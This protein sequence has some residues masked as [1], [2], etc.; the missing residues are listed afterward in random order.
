[1][2]D[3]AVAC[4]AASAAAEGGGPPC[5]GAP[6]RAAP[7]PATPAAPTPCRA[8]PGAPQPL[9]RRPTEGLPGPAAAS[10]RT[11]DLRTCWTR[12]PLRLPPSV[13]SAPPSP[14]SM[15]Q[16]LYHVENHKSGCSNPNTCITTSRHATVICTEIRSR[17]SH[18]SAG[19][20]A[21]A[22]CSNDEKPL[23]PYS[24][25]CT[26][27]T[28]SARTGEYGQQWKGGKGGGGGG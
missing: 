22:S 27:V 12:T 21:Q 10:P 19:H 26:A 24:C 4:V 3:H 28:G 15:T 8:R 20:N 25:E 7:A 23:R 5:R 1:M 6:G 18:K 14:Q 17:I 2:E 13:A 16:L 11:L 9:C